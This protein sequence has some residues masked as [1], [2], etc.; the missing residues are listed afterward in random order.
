MGSRPRF[1]DDLSRV[2]PDAA[3]PAPSGDDALLDAYSRT[4]I[5][6]LERVQQA[7]A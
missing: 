7:V 5:G 2:S 1:I 6:A 4:V 3:A